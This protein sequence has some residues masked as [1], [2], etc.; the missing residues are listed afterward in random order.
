MEAE[1]ARRRIKTAVLSNK[2]DIY[3]SR[4]TDALLAGHRFEIGGQEVLTDVPPDQVKPGFRV[5]CAGR[6]LE[7]SR[8]GISEGQ[9]RFEEEGGQGNK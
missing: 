2:S 3:T 7:G 6:R 5:G 4:M 9:T 1:L 8:I